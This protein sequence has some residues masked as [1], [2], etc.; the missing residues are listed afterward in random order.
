MSKMRVHKN[1]VKAQQF[2]TGLLLLVFFITPIGCQSSSA[3]QNVTK[4]PRPVKAL[5]LQVP[6]K[7]IIRTFP[8][9]AKAIRETD[10][11]F[12]VGGPLLVLNAETGQQVE[13]GSVISRV[14]PRD[15]RVRVKTMEAQLVA[16]RARLEE[17]ELQFQRYGGL[18]ETN[19]A[20]KAAYDRVK[21]TYEIAGAKVDADVESLED[22]RNA[23][24]D[25]VLR[26]PF[27]GFI[28]NEYVENYETVSG[29]QSIVSLVDLAVIEVEVSLPED[30][31]PLVDRFES[32][33]CRFD[34]LPKTEFSATFKEVGKKP[35]AS[36]RSYPLTLTLTQKDVSQ[37]FIRPGMATEVSI[38]LNGNNVPDRFVVPATAVANS[39]D[40]ESYV[41]ILDNA[42]RQVLRRQVRLSGLAEGGI[43]IEGD[44]EPG[45]WVVVAGV[46]SLT[47]GQKVRLL[48]A[49]SI[50][51]IGGEL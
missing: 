43:F 9:T 24:K 25:T 4:L 10:L 38:V 13:S 6:P 20:A 42:K 22:A 18:L 49:P 48:S 47:Q 34:A 23:L 40:S 11:S 12:R 19:A 7:E 2:L 3:D 33:T 26:A 45:L 30:Y 41:W 27:T 32:Y 37:T 1:V 15:F 21:A 14:D 31:L 8:G 16:S 46:N 5:P 44:L 39:S 50:T 35:N 28:H 29:G 36:N 17:T 51:N